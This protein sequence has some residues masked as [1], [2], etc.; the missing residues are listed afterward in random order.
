MMLNEK[1][2]QNLVFNFTKE[3]QFTAEILLKNEK[4][5]TVDKTKLLGVIITNDLK[6]HENTKHIVKNANM[7]M[8]MLH[9]FSK[10]TKNKSHLM[11][12]FKSQVR[13][14]LE[15]CSTVW[16]SSLTQSNCNDIE[17]VQKAAMRVIMGTRYQ[18]YEEALE[19]MKIDSLR[20]RRVKMALKFAKKSI[21]QEIFSPL[22]PLNE[23]L[24]SM[25]TRNPKKY[26]VKK[27]N[28]ERMRRSSVP[29][30]QR[31]LNEDFDKQKKDLSRLLQV[32]NGIL[33]N[34]PITY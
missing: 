13:G 27:G 21:R 30:L 14:S 32:N 23:N 10:F 22:F 34:A 33:F 18:G 4:L 19:F 25:K 20:E 6:W 29:F 1:K 7:K 16:H 31:L 28:T 24:H 9:K 2:T 8:R 12:I 17:R 15:Y 11:H 5:E 26:V 3:H